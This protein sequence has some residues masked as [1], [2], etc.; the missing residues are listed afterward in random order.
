MNAVA[1]CA[2]CHIRFT[3]EP[4]EWADWCKK[5]FGEDHLDLLIEKKNE[6][7]KIPKIEEKEIANY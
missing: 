6:V 5:Y 4:F 1:L 7:R 2:G 3:R